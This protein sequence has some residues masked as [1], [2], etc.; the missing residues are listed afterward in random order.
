MVLMVLDIRVE[1]VLAS[2]GVTVCHEKLAT[3]AGLVLEA[4]HWPRFLP[5]EGYS[6]ACF[7]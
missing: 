1:V 7:S 4:D 5:L 6:L 3:A 2:E